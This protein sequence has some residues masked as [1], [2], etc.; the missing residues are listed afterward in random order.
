MTI[1]RER[2]RECTKVLMGSMCRKA[3]LETS[4]EKKK[5]KKHIDIV[6]TL[7]LCAKQR[8]V[9]R[10]ISVHAYILNRGLLHEDIYLG[11]ALISLYIRCGM[12]HDAQDVFDSLPCHDLATWNAL[13]GG[14]ARLGH[15]E[16]ALNC[17]ERLRQN[18]EKFSPNEVTLLCVLN[19]CGGIGALYKGQ[20]VHG[21]I[22][23]RGFLRTNALLG[24][25]L[26]D[27][28]GQCG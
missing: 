5:K 22:C 23:R 26:V 2:E 12:P 16:S 8:D 15:G 25:A 27:M 18:E 11:S 19:A 24:C 28:Y 9:V 3:S 20:E 13:I 4:Q 6:A 21:E 17:Y 14:Y 10:G 1:E 7:K